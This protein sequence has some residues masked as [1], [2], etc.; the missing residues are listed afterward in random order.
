MDE[1]QETKAEEVKQ[2]TK[3]EETQQDTET[4]KE[5][6]LEKET[7]KTIN[8]AK[9]KMKNINL[10][11]EAEAGKGLL[12]KLW[13]KP[14]ETI[15]EVADDKENKTFKTAL[16][17]VIVWAIIEFVKMVLHYVTSKYADFEFLP[18]LRVAIVPIIRVIA[19]TLAL[20]LINNRAKQSISK[21]LTSV[22]I[23]YTPSVIYSFV[24][25]LHFISYRMDTILIPI[26][27]LLGVVSTVLMYQ[28]VKAFSDEKEE[29]ILK[30]FVKVEAVYYIIAFVISF[31]GISI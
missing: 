7:V 8:E 5:S 16:L 2:D 4:K 17:L 25:L 15:K 19:M 28:T 6:E 27:G 13:D 30:K 20:Y 9:E 12:K 11:E 14:V 22:S 31:L 21:V 10:K 24:Y 26:G 23:A 18:T 1:N 29:N 3:V